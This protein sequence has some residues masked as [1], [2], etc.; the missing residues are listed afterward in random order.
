VRLAG[1][2]LAGATRDAGP[3]AGPQG[4]VRRGRG[5]ARRGRGRGPPGRGSP[6]TGRAR[7]EGARR[8]G[9]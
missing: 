1:A 4:G 9:G 7:G 5:G 6:G 2:R 3:G 8:G